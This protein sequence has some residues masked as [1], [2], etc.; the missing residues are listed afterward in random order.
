MNRHRKPGRYYSVEASGYE[1]C[2]QPSKRATPFGIGKENF[3]SEAID[4]ALIAQFIWWH[5]SGF[6]QG[7]ALI[8][9]IGVIGISA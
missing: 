6:G 4:S 3:Y 8:N 5:Y 9:G 2:Q 7:L 1:N